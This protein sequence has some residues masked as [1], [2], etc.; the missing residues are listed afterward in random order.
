MAQVE[1]R[2]GEGNPAAGWGNVGGLPQV[3]PESLVNRATL[4]IGEALRAYHR[5][6]IRG[7]RHLTK[8]LAG[9]GPVLI[10][11]NHCMDVVDPL[12]LAT[13]V[14]RATGRIL[15]FVAH[16]KVF[17]ELPL[18]RSLSRSWGFVPNGR[19]DHAD[20]ALQS[21]GALVIYPGGASEA[22]LRS[23]RTEPYRLKW[24]GRLGFVELALR[25]RATLL[26]AAGVGID[27]LYFQTRVPIPRLLLKY[28]T[29]YTGHYQGARFGLGATG[30]HVLP[31]LTPLPVRVT[32]VFSTPLSL[33]YGID[34]SDRMVLERVQRRIWARCQRALDAAVLA[35]RRDSD[36]VDA[37]C[38]RAVSTLQ[39]VGL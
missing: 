27:E 12:M 24:E 13:A 6:H 18:L 37:V 22:I 11:G 10:V 2:S 21:G 14:Y 16:G 39:R 5:H 28:S 29:G 36:L 8:A 35:R 19:M 34:P 7:M 17:F 38:R 9:P 32:H 20:A 23:Y 15:R 31:G 33:D 26:F 1:G 25:R 30:L 3:D 4:G